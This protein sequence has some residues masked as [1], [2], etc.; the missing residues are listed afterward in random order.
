MKFINWIRSKQ[1]LRNGAMWVSL[2][3]QGMLAAQLLGKIFGYDLTPTMGNDITLATNAILVVLSTL[4]IVSNP[5]NPE[6]KGFN[7]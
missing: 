4:G 1:R 6:S 2:V 7:L 5:A 3:S